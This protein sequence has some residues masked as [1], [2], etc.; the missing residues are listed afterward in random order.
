MSKKS[1]R[2]KIAKPVAELINKDGE[3]VGLEYLWNNGHVQNVLFNQS[4]PH[5][6][7]VEIASQKV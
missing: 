2:H 7:R 6:D 1:E 4:K 3:T 5:T